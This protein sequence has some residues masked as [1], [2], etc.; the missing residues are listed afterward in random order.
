MAG[1]Y[2]AWT[3]AGLPMQQGGEIIYPDQIEAR[4]DMEEFSASDSQQTD[5]PA[6]D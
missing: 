2:H 3:I 1:G 4:E 5:D 6:S